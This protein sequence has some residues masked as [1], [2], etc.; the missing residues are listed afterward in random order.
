MPFRKIV[1]NPDF[2]SE[3]IAVGDFDCNGV[4]DVVAGP[5]WYQGPDFQTRHAIFTPS[6]FDPHGYSRT[7]QPCFVHD[8]TGNGWPD[9]FYVIRPKGLRGNYGFYG[10]DGAAGWEGVWYENPAGVSAPWKAHHVL[11]NIANEAV[12]WH[13][14]DGDGRPEPVYTTREQVGYAKFDPAAP[15]QPWRFYAVADIGPVTLSHGIGCGD[16]SG[17]GRPDIIGAGGWW[18]HPENPAAGNAWTFHP[19]LFSQSA[20]TLHVRDVSGNGLNDVITVW[21]AHGY[22]LVWHEQLR[23][24]DGKLSWQRH[25]ILAPEPDLESNALRISQMHALA[26]ADITGDGLPDLVVGK[27]AWAHGPDGDVEA[28]QPAVLYWFET[29]RQKDGSI[30]FIPHLVDDDSGAGTQ[31]AVADLTGQGRPAILTSNKKGA[32][33]FLPTVK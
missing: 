14:V 10:W 8:F 12:I 33:V 31:I 25:D 24:H 21:H 15:E 6:S 29:R 26:A 28:D 19:E 32:C 27:R 20:V 17:N 22:G 4:M 23:D 2:T 18:E 13:D 9:V 16:I 7:T 3:S 1:L 30:A 5:F 11:G